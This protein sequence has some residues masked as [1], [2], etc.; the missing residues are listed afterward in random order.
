MVSSQPATG[1]WLLTP[2]ERHPAPTSIPQVSSAYAYGRKAVSS[3]CMF[4]DD[5]I[6]FAKHSAPRM[7]M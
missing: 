6:L 7:K 5:Q 1:G 2:E 4:H 3:F